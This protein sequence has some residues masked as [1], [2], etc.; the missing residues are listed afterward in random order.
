[1]VNELPLNPIIAQLLMHL[2]DLI[3]PL[4]A[5]LLMLLINQL[6]NNFDRLMDNFERVVDNVDRVMD[7]VETLTNLTNQGVTGVGRLFDR[8]D[9]RLTAVKDGFTAAKDRFAA[10]LTAMQAQIAHHSDVIWGHTGEISA[11]K[12]QA[13]KDKDQQDKINAANEAKISNPTPREGGK[14]TR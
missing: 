4:A 3:N 7:N 5:Q 9:A 2:M 14:T 10:R 13:A 11:L 12:I 1:M 8:L 6:M